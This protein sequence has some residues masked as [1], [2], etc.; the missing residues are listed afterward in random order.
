MRVCVILG[1]CLIKLFY[2][3][4][5]NS[6]EE[7]AYF[8]ILFNAVFSLTEQRD[9]EKLKQVLAR[10]EMRTSGR[11]SWRFHADPFVLAVGLFALGDGSA[12]ASFSYKLWVQ[13]G[14]GGEDDFGRHPTAA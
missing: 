6:M 12:L 14:G 2:T 9:S 3:L 11:K 8:R 5:K 1:M 7:R 10:P 13:A 4:H